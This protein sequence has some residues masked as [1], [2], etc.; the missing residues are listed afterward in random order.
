MKLFRWQIKIQSVYIL[1]TALWPLIDIETFMMITGYKTD[2]WLVK[3]VGALLIPV[4][5]TLGSF[6]FVHTDARPAFLLGAL[7]ALAF[8]SVDF[9]YSLTD[10]ISNIYMLDGAIEILFLLIWIYLSTQ[11][12]KSR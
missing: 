11:T 7:T 6:L 5:L 1:I 3:T 4:S 10:V 9:Y 2:I 12:N 8:I